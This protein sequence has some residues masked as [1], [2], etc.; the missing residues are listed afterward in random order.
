VAIDWGRFQGYLSGWSVA[1]MGVE[2]VSP[3]TED[4]ISKHCPVETGI[5]KTFN[6]SV[7]LLMSHV[8][9]VKSIEI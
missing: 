2:D 5:H 8:S 7:S 9:S 4:P 1:T 3:I 6:S